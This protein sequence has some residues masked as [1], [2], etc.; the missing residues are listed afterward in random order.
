MLNKSESGFNKFVSPKSADNDFAKQ[1]PYYRV[2]LLYS[3]DLLNN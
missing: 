1:I 3:V 2:C